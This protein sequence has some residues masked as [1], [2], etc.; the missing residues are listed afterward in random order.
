MHSD[1]VQWEIDIGYINLEKAKRPTIAVVI[2]HTVY[3]L[4][5]F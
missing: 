1:K 5:G 2:L 4:K 3:I